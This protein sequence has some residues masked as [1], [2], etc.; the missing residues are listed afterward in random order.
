MFN[1]QLFYALHALMKESP[2][3]HWERDG[4]RATNEDPLTRS[5][6]DG[7]I[8]PSR[9]RGAYGA[10]GERGPVDGETTVLVPVPECRPW[11]WA[12]IREWCSPHLRAANQELSICYV[13]VM[14]VPKL[15]RHRAWKWQL[16]AL[17]KAVR[18]VGEIDAVYATW[19]YPDGVAATL[20]AKELSVPAWIMVQGSDVFHLDSEA[21]RRVILDACDQATGVVCV[22]E[23]LAEK[24]KQA[25][26]DEGKIHVVDNGV[27]G[28][29]FRYR[30]Q[31]EARERLGCL[32][33]RA[34]APACSVY[35]AGIAGRLEGPDIQPPEAAS[36]CR[37]PRHG[38]DE[39]ERERMNP[40]Q[41]LLCQ[42]SSVGFPLERGEKVVLFVGN[43]V[44][45]KGPDRLLAAMRRVVNGDSL[46][47]NG[48][49]PSA[50]L[51]LLGDG[52]MRN[53]LMRQARQLGIAEHVCFLGSRSHDE[54]AL[55]MN[56]ADCL[57]LPSR[58]EGMPNV[59][60]EAL[61]SGLPVAATDVG[62]VRE[63][64]EG[65][66]GCR[67]LGSDGDMAQI[68]SCVLAETVDRR[69]LAEA[70]RD[71]FSWKRTAQTVLGLISG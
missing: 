28:E 23:H 1:A 60:V 62:N 19:L 55:W 30:T 56:A 48:G 59:V 18:T 22:A 25:G 44:P 26:V 9:L 7:P 57:C 5:A 70:N 49:E 27:D 43:L 12:A 66:I 61:A 6:G 71:R 14:H 16:K 51:I 10:P 15:G 11:R 45:V 68:I 32:A 69:A 67:V 29:V 13:P 3:S 38:G 54:V 34:P 36:G 40:S 39:A 58:S 41:L 46:I 35:A 17:R 31:A 42:D 21:R 20:L 33:T 4:V 24:L 64:L 53:R 37:H 63:L 8:S 47:V 50:K 2:L 52:P 65:Q